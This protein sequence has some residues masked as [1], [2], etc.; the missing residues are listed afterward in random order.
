MKQA[1]YKTVYVDCQYDIPFNNGMTARELKDVDHF[2]H[3]PSS[4]KDLEAMR[5][6]NYFLSLL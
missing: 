4:D 6:V 1:G 2:Y 3:P 5:F